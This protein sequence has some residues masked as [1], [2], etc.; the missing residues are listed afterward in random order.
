[1]WFDI[2][3]DGILHSHRRESLRSEAGSAWFVHFQ[4]L[5]LGYNRLKRNIE[6]NEEIR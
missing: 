4:C 6:T 5:H 3:E 2:P 1:M